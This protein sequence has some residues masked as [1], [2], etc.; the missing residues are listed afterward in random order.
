MY[1]LELKR[2]F[3]NR[4]TVICL[5]LGCMIAGI[6]VVDNLLGNV[7]YWNAEQLFVKNSYIY[8]STVFD[9]WM[10]GN[11]YNLEG[12]VYFMVFPLL[13]ALPFA[14]S[15]FEDM[16]HGIIRQIYTRTQ[17]ETYLKAKY[18]AVFLSAGTI[19]VIPLILNFLVCMMLLPA[20]T[21]EPLAAQGM[22]YSSVL[23]YEIYE[24][25]P[26]LY[27]LIFFI[28]DFVFSG[29]LATVALTAALFTEKK[30]VSLI[31]PFVLHIFA[32]S[33]CMMTGKANGVMYAPTYFLLAGA[34]CVSWW[35]YVFYGIF[36]L[37]CGSI[38]YVTGKN[39]DWASDCVR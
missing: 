2:A 6:H 26:F 25:Y 14:A 21:P 27:E 10:A 18:V 20:V 16:Q 37:V 28:I 17:R 39:V 36:F 13:T 19:F 24:K 38:Y 15:Y 31:T 3:Y 11:T 12:F 7:E 32:Y 35:I 29:F 1:G 9:A 4:K 33:V 22:I 8:P 23:W 5:I 34:G 30:I